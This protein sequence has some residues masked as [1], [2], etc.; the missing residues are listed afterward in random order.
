M[1][2]FLKLLC[3]ISNR[4]ANNPRI[5][6]KFNAPNIQEYVTNGNSFYH[7]NEKWYMISVI[8]SSPYEK[9]F[10]KEKIPQSDIKQSINDFLLD[11]RYLED[12]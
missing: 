11:G 6:N 8:R 10:S 5:K 4:C 12:M 3:F 7:R 1:K 9:Y 2:H